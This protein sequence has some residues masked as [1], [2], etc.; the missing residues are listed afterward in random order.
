MA[1]LE[2]PNE[3][4]DGFNNNRSNRK[5]KEVTPNPK[6]STLSLERQLKLRVLLNSIGELKIEKPESRNSKGDKLEYSGYIRVEE[7]EIVDYQNNVKE[8]LTELLL[9]NFELFDQY[10][11]LIGKG[12]ID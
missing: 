7:A 1:L 10:T 9:Q 12:L 5:P 3:G 6:V 8:V 11:K 2:P 4:D